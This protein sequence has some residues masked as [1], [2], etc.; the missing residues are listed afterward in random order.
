MIPLCLSH[1]VFW[2]TYRLVTL[3]SAWSESTSSGWVNYQLFSI[4]YFRVSW[5]VAL[6]Q[7]SAIVFPFSKSRTLG[8]Y[9]AFLV[10]SCKVIHYW[11]IQ[12]I[13]FSFATL[14]NRQSIC[15]PWIPMAWWVE[16]KCR[17][18]SCACFSNWLTWWPKSL[19]LNQSQTLSDNTELF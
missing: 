4:N 14:F 12:I 5:K 9:T 2:L 17:D 6:L 13:M 15:S 11:Q 8:W 10:K 18:F 7:L 3:W 16:M 19:F 1:L